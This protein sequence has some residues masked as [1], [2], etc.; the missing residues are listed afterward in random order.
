VAEYTLLTWIGITEPWSRIFRVRSTNFTTVSTSPPTSGRH[1]AV[2]KLEEARRQ[3]RSVGHRANEKSLAFNLA[4]HVNHSLWWKNLSPTAVT[5]RPVSSPLPSTRRSVVRQVPGSVHRG[6][7][8]CAGLWLG[9]ARL[10][11]PR[12]EAV[13]IP[14]LRPP[15]QFPARLVPLLVLDMWEHAFYLQYKNVKQ[16]LPRR[17]GMS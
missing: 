11:Q 5:S 12:R 2:A 4:G 15:D 8:H 7:D 1:D 16:T 10:G 14:G 17:I 3:G 6:R 13:G 9:R